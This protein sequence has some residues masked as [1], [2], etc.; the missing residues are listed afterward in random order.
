MARPL[1]A[2]AGWVRGVCWNHWTDLF[3]HG[4]GEGRVRAQLDR[5]LG[6]CVFRALEEL[7]TNGQTSLGCGGRGGGDGGWWLGGKRRDAASTLCN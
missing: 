4:V 5:P 7:G 2:C 1:R 6:A 3:G